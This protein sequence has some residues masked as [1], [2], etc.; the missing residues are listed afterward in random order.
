MALRETFI[1]EDR[2]S[3]CPGCEYSAPHL[4]C[5][6]GKPFEFRTHSLVFRQNE[7]HIY[8]CTACGLVF[9]DSILSDESFELLYGDVDFSNWSACQ[10]YPSE[11]PVLRY[12]DSLPAGSRVLDFGC[13]SGRLMEQANPR[14]AKWGFEVNKTA[15][16]EAV[17]KGIQMLAD[18]N[19]LKS[20]QQTFDAVLLMDV[21]EHLSKPTILLREMTELVK[22]GGML[23]VSTGNAD[24]RACQTDISNF[25]YF[26]SIQ[27]LCMITK[28]YAACFAEGAGLRLVSWQE[29]SHYETKFINRTAQH[30][31]QWIYAFRHQHPRSALVAAMDWLPILRKS[32]TWKIPPPY[33]ASRDHTVL[34]FEK[35]EKLGNQ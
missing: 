16:R 28:H 26:R 29:C 20:L 2:N 21:F 8:R 25:W 32:A 5:G 13:S 1:P 15:A 34:F 30:L 35:T 22:T 14:I 33:S 23:V 11:R 18:W 17:A 19:N 7:Y 27:H 12:L 3:R 24:C 31:R 10:T 9:K 6:T 4:L